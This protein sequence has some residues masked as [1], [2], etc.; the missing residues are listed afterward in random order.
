MKLNMIS[1]EI[2]NF[3]L[4]I[5]LHDLIY[6]FCNL[7]FESNHKSGGFLSDGLIFTLSHMNFH[8]FG[9][10]MFESGTFEGTYWA[11]ETT[12]ISNQHNQYIVGLLIKSLSIDPKRELVHDSLYGISIRFLRLIYAIARMICPNA[13][14]QNF[15]TTPCSSLSKH[16][17]PC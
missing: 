5:S 8:V 7:L 11:M 2:L 6:V 16:E 3:H 1:D 10:S 4:N 13:S 14:S 12:L 17:G 9:D 15:L